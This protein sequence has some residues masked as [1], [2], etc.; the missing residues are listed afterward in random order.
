MNKAS[1]NHIDQYKLLFYLSWIVIYFIF[2]E[3]Y[4]SQIYISFADKLIDVRFW[5]KTIGF[6]A[7]FFISAFILNSYFKTLF[8]DKPVFDNFNRW[9]EVLRDNVWFTIV[10]CISVVL[11]IFTVPLHV[12]SPHTVIDRMALWIYQFI[13][14]Y[15]YTLCDVPIQYP[16]WLF[17]L[18]FILILTQKKLVNFISGLLSS[19][20]TDYKS[21][22]SL[23]PLYIT[24]MVAIFFAYMKLIPGYSWQDHLFITSEAPVG[25]ILYLIGYSLFGTEP[26]YFVPLIVQLAF[27]VLSGVFMY[28]T[29]R[30]FHD[31]ET[32]LLGSSLYL[33]SPIIFTYATLGHLASGVIFLIIVVSYFFLK[34]IR[35]AD[36]KDLIMTAYFIGI[37]SLYKREILLMFFV[38][39]VYLAAKRIKQK[40]IPLLNHLKILSLSLLTFLPLYFIGARGAD[41]MVFSHLTSLNS[42]SSYFLMIPTQ[43]SWPFFI[44]FLLS[45]VFVL[46]NRREPLSL[47]FGLVLIAYY[48]L[49][50]LLPQQSVHRYSMAFHPTISVFL[51]Q[52]ICAS[53]QKIKWRHAYKLVFTVLL[54]YLGLLCIVPRSSTN[55]ITFKYTDFENQSFPDDKAR[56]WIRN[57]LGNNEKVLILIRRSKSPLIQ[58]KEHFMRLNQLSQLL[59]ADDYDAFRDNLKALCNKMKITHIMFPGGNA[60]QQYPKKEYRELEIRNFLEEDTYD[61]FILR[62]KF[63]IDDNYI[64]IYELRDNFNE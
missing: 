57:E 42:L 38:C 44:L 20:Y 34:F 30:L 29:I 25:T 53:L 39:C 49:Y 48:L 4:F 7:Y 27:Y 12:V 10:C 3:W 62:A 59:P 2:P 14:N 56:E 61:D 55:L 32:A 46:L 24:V 37:G 11:H 50:T 36:N 18:F 1:K 13:T 15:W 6:L 35:D 40:D 8:V 22:N 31:K 43:I 21:R 26:I 9:S 19:M 51:A 17:L 45:I 33:F 28:K 64:Y 47:L 63:N 5:P 52:F 16:A 23:K 58:G 41:G 60:A 54:I